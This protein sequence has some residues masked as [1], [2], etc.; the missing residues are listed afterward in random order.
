MYFMDLKL[1][2]PLKR[3][4]FRL[5]FN[6]RNIAEIWLF[7]GDVVTKLRLSYWK[8]EKFFVQELCNALV[9]KTERIFISHKGCFN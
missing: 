7:E 9:H 4:R 5:V 1:I 8:L 2:A 3:L 6:V